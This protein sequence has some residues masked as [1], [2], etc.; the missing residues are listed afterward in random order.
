MQNYFYLDNLA[1][2]SVW[3]HL[4]KNINDCSLTGHGFTMSFYYNYNFSWI[5]GNNKFL[6]LA[7]KCLQI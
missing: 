7:K 2:R 5:K 4:N 6:G 3:Q 1:A